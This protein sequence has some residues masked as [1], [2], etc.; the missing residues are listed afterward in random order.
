MDF[1]LYHY[2]MEDYD[3]IGFGCSYR[4]IQT[5]LSAYKKYYDNNITIPNIRELL[6]YFNKDYLNIV[7]KKD[8]WI[9][10]YHISNYLFQ[11]FNIKFINTIYV[12]KDED[13]TKI[14]K[15]DINVYLSNKTYHKN[16]FIEL[17]NL[18]K[19]HF[20]KSKLPI[21]ID[22]GVYSYCIKT[23]ND[24]VI[25]IDPH[26][27]SDDNVIKH[28]DISFIKNTFWMIYLPLNY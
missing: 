4:N 15:T 8:L 24:K 25:L 5:I 20:S 18:F 19:I 9:E 23:I 13:I 12:T 2:G 7:N 27:T 26:T 6:N 17:L 14:L 10:P 28:K 11:N 1:K 16:N 22:N 21:I 3:D